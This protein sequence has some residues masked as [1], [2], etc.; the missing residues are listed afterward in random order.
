MS[1]IYGFSAVACTLLFLSCG[2]AGSTDTA[3]YPGGS[4]NK[5]I[6]GE[7]EQQLSCIDKNS[8]NK[9]DPEERKPSG[10]KLGY[11]WFRFNEGGNCAWDKD[12]KLEGNYEV[13]ENSGKKKLSIRTAAG[14]KVARYTISTVNSDE[15]ILTDNGAF[16]VFKRIR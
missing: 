14:E 11:D 2:N 5:G 15:M 1:R 10:M 13:I 16:M 8:N 6:A 4:Q 7:W 12:M 9:L 3:S